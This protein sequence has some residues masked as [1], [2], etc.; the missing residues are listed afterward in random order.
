LV[1]GFWKAGCVLL[2]GAGASYS[3]RAASCDPAPAGLV[4]WWAGDGSTADFAG[5]NNASL[6]SGAAVTAA[7]Q[8]GNGFTFDGA[9][10]YVQIPDAPALKPANLTVETWV[11]FASLTSTVSGAPAGEQYMV[12]KQNTRVGNFE[13]YYLGKTRISSTDRFTFQVSSAAGASIELDSVTSIAAG[14]WYHVAAVR[15]SN[16]AQLYVNGALEAQASVSFAQDYGTQPLYFGTSGQSYWDGKLNGM[17]DEVSLY[18][19]ALS[20]NEVA[21]VFAAG[22]AGKC[23]GAS[24]VTQPQSQTVAAGS[25]ALFSV[26]ASGYGTLGYQW[27]FNGATLPGATASTLTL[28]NVQATNA[29]SYVAVVSNTLGAAT[30][31]AATLTVLLRPAI[32]AQPQNS[33]NEC[34]SSAAFA[35]TATGTSPLSYQWYFNGSP[36]PG[37]TGPTLSIGTAS[38]AQQGTYAV[39]V[40]NVV[41]S[42]TSAPA[43]LNVVDRTP[44]L[45]TL[46]GA[47]PSTN[48]CHA[49]FVDP[50]ATA[51]DTCAGAL[52]V[53]T[54]SN[55]NPNAPGVYT[56][57]YVAT[58]FSGNSTTNTRTVYIVDRTAPIVT[59]T[60]ANPLT[61]E[62]HAVLVDPG[63][64]ATDACAGALSVATNST[65]NP[66]AAGTY[67]IRYTA[68]DPSGNAVTNTRVVVV[69]DRTPPVVTLLGPP[70]LTNECHTAFTDPGAT[71]SDACAAS[72]P[73][74]TNGGVNPNSVGQYVLTYVATDP[75]GNSATNTRTVYVV[76]TTAPSLTLNGANPFTNE[77]HVPFVDPGASAVD[78]CAGSLPVTT[79]NS[80][81]PNAPGTYTVRYT[82]ADPSGNSVTNTRVVVVVD[83]TPPVIT[84]IGPAVVTNECHSAFLDPGATAADSC[85]GAI[86]IVTNNPVNPNAPGVYTVVYSATDPSGNSA[87][88]SRTVYVADRTAPLITLNGANPMTNE[89]HAAFTDPGATGADLCA[90]YL[91]VNA[92]S[93]VNPNAP[94]AY[95][96]TYVAT[97]PSGNSATNTRLVY[98][99]D[100]TAPVITLNGQNPMTNECHAAFSDPGA[101]ATDACAGPLGV[102]SSSFV[103]PDAA[104]VYTIAYYATD[105]SGN[106]T[107]NVRT[108]Y[109]VDRTPPAIISAV[110]SLTIFPNANCQAVLPNLT[111]PSS[112]VAADSCSSVAVAQFP[113]A[114][115]LFSL[116]STNSVTLTAFDTAGNA[117]N[118]FVTVVVPAAPFIVAQPTNLTV[119]VSNSASLTVAACGVGALRYQWL[120]AN[121]NLP[122]ATNAVL[123]LAVAGTNDSGNYTVIVT[124]SAG[125]ATSAVA[126]LAV[127]PYGIVTDPNLNAIVMGLL[128]KTTCDV[129]ALDLQALTNI[130]A[131]NANIT[132]LAGLSAATN[133]TSLY[134]GGNYIKDLTPLQGLRGLTSLYLQNNLVTNL[135]PL[136]GLTNLALLDVRWNPLANHEAVLGAMGGLTDLYLGGDSVT[137]VAFLQPVSGLKFLALDHTAVADL[138]PLVNLTNLAGLDLSYGSV[139]NL[140]LLNAF[141]RLDSLYLSGDTLTN[142]S[143]LTNVASLTT[144]SLCSNQLAAVPALSGATNLNSLHLGGNP[145]LAS[146]AGLTALTS[147]T[148]LWVSG[149]NLSAAAPFQALTWLGY[150]NVDDNGI[151]D[152]SPLASLWGLR[153]LSADRNLITNGASL[154]ALTNLTALWLG[155]NTLGNVSFMAGLSRLTAAEL[156]GDLISN[157]TPLSGL[158]QLNHLSL[159]G[160]SISDATPL[161]TLTNLVELYLG[162]QGSLSDLSFVSTLTQLTTLDLD[163]NQISDLAPLAGLSRLASLDLNTN[164]IANL[165]PLAGSPNLTSL[166]V[167]QNRL[168]DLGVLPTLPRLLNADVRL[169]L[170]DF[171]SGSPARSVF[172]TLATRCPTVATLPSQPDTAP[173]QRTPPVITLNTTLAT[174]VNGTWPIAAGT[175]SRLSFTVADSGPASQAIAV[176]AISSNES[177]IPNSGLAA[178]LSAGGNGILTVT[179][180]LV[181]SNYAVVTLSATND[182]GLSTNINIAVSVLSPQTV[183]LPDPNL[184][185]TVRAALGKPTGN[186]T[187]LDMMSL[188]DLSAGGRLITNLAGIEYAGNLLTL[189][190]VQNS[191]ADIHALANLPRI[192]YVDL[193]WNLLDLS[194]GSPASGVVKD[195]TNRNVVVLY[196]P[197]RTPPTIGAASA[198]TIGPNRSSVFFFTASDAVASGSQLKLGAKSSN[199]TLIPNSGLALARYVYDPYW[200]LTATPA[201][202]MTGATIVTLSATNEVGLVSTWAIAV[203]VVPPVP[204]AGGPLDGWT[205]MNWQSSAN[206]PWFVQTNVSHNGQSSAQSGAIADGQES[207]LQTTVNGPGTL[208]FWEK[209]SSEPNFDFLEFYINDILQTNLLIS[210]ETD[211]VQRSVTLS[212]GTYTLRWEYTKDNSGKIGSDASWLAEV[213]FLLSGL[214]LQLLGPPAGNQA[215]LL[216]YGTVGNRYQIDAS[217]NLVN[218]GPLVI[219]TNTATN[220]SGVFPYADMLPPGMPKRYYRAKQLQ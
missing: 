170:L 194:N 172:Q 139:T 39:V 61:N 73:V 129:T 83:K 195:L 149:N 200:T 8:V 146:Y 124:N 111:T 180:A 215:N 141:P 101:S 79:D 171:S 74:S 48:E 166:S 216:V 41:G 214:R 202:G 59:L 13:G 126:V 169:N 132:N 77:C 178:V 168:V 134:L 121:T 62:C 164:R 191:I 103:N 99:V 36:L 115:A 197:Q 205:G 12:F 3:G 90:G 140:A 76:D 27:R 51:S 119:V 6:V 213:S 157:V 107:T 94:G 34:G 53:S 24:I 137:N 204:L 163:S 67:N 57:R 47:N 20:S 85:A 72:L 70:S 206:A 156:D 131:P 40:T 190:L 38:S 181:T 92:T 5:T 184:N 43:T 11:K 125:S 87:T 186:L 15:G 17:L 82:A 144:L 210:G 159:R 102:S 155:G 127:F 188:T 19:R 185:A 80:V 211:W 52:P 63:A 30:S 120:H 16:F 93:T 26:S 138:S 218:W 182:A 175:G 66:N 49:V 152:P 109:I 208:S 198:W 7:G 18:N 22:A 91:G 75:S 35:V 161:A 68:V 14:V 203:S 150:L 207:W 123:F 108:V 147:V 105:P 167:G 151:R 192:L 69:V 97:D 37:A 106:S 4:G 217:T 54:N 158:R 60:G 142:L 88:I 173:L 196:L 98:I 86:D 179:P 153:T 193:V 176:G 2:I 45:V 145:T 55:L 96:I 148:N 29:G 130:Y 89:C 10:S 116:G 113:A 118:R 209:V 174:L 154:A 187:T 31:S 219:F 199:T 165:G 58:D 160:N 162:A 100:R 201:N 143:F 71:A 50:G 21:A 46:L 114:G 42:V 95:A 135:A 136:S 133:L 32:T 110:S 33:T 56:L 78:N 81:N 28:T 183:T 212:A 25:N 64:S 220:T 44:P 65:V 189:D 128:G 122:N 9:A 117:T 84:L 104:G 23:K 1:G 177:V 112:I